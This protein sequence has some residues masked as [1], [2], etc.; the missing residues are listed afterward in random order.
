M[1][2]NIV[3]PKF[4]KDLTGRKFGALTVTRFF[5]MSDKGYG[6][7]WMC[8]C[9][10]G[11]EKTILA[12]GLK[13]AK[14]CGCLSPKRRI[15]LTGKQFGRLTVVQA[16]GIT[17]NKSVRWLCQCD[18][19]H[20]KVIDGASLRY[21]ATRSCGCLLVETAKKQKPR[22]THGKTKTKVYRA[23]AKMKARCKDTNDK[24]WEHYGGRGISVCSRWS[25]FESFY[26]DMGEPPTEEHSLDRIDVNGDYCRENCR[27]ATPKEQARNQRR[28]NLITFNGKTQCLAD[29]AEELGIRYGTLEARLN[30]YQWPVEKAFSTPVAHRS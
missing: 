24:R 6:A 13:K 23:W 16:S 14:S 3:L 22:L 17:K 8:K 21:G 9:K 26:A 7:I 10:C 20:K 19:G 15:N 29:W 28:S 5:G 12:N 4:V 18:C 1:A 27:W 2:K 11:T 25:D 30:A